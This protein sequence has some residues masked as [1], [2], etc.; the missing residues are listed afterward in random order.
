MKK[1][2]GV[3]NIQ[4]FTFTITTKMNK[5]NYDGEN[6]VTSVH[7]NRLFTLSRQKHNAIKY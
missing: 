4:P 1:H 6:S 7:I 3:S 2:Y 5:I